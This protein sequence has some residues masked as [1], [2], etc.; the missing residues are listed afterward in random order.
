ML[1]SSISHIEFSNFYASYVLQIFK[2]KISQFLFSITFHFKK[3]RVWNNKKIIILLFLLSK[4]KCIILI[5][6]LFLFHYEEKFIG[7]AKWKDLIQARKFSN[8]SRFIVDLSDINDGGE[9]EKVYHGIYPTA[10]QL[11][12]KNSSKNEVSFLDLEIKIVNKK[13]S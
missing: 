11:R 9:F 2:T 1:Q 6:K 8:I 13:F 4:R 5:R 7:K 3:F 10:L 12:R